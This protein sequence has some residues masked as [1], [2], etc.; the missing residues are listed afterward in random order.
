MRR[1]STITRRWRLQP[2]SSNSASTPFQPCPADTQSWRE[3]ACWMSRFTLLLCFNLEQILSLP[4]LCLGHHPLSSPATVASHQGRPRLRRQTIDVFPELRL[5]IRRRR[6]SAGR[7][8]HVQHQSNIGRKIGVIHVRWSPRLAGVVAF[9]RAFLVAIERLD[10]GVDI[11]NPGFPQERLVAVSQM[12]CPRYGLALAG[13][14]AVSAHGTGN[15][16]SGEADLF[17]S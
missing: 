14:Y 7:R 8:F 2:V 5:R 12:P 4:F 10:G 13:G 3:N 15:R 11:Q 16:P 9:H 1:R 17:T 6:L